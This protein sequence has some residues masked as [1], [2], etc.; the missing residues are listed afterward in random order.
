M[1]II[2]IPQNLP[3]F[4]KKREVNRLLSKNLEFYTILDFYFIN[5]LIL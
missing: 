1:I 2:V 5:I 4:F 3:A